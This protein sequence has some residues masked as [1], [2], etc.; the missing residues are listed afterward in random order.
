MFKK[1]IEV[2]LLILNYFFKRKTKT[3]DDDLAKQADQERLKEDKEL[4]DAIKSGDSLTVARIREK[5]K[6]YKHI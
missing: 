2:L 4:F 5:R 6:H 3:M 1:I